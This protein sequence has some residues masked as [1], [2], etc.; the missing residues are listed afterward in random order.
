MVELRSTKNM[1]TKQNKTK[2]KICVFFAEPAN[3]TQI[4]K[5]TKSSYV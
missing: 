3:P 2:E 5:G 4:F 1:P